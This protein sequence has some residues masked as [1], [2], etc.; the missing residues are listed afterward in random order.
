MSRPKYIIGDTDPTLAGIMKPGMK[1]KVGNDL[2]QVELWFD[3]EGE[4]HVEVTRWIKC[5]LLLWNKVTEISFG[6]F[7][8]LKDFRERSSDE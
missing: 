2:N 8:D 6:P 4:L 7:F 3:D 5:D 1:I